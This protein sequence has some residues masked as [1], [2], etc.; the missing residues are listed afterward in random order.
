MGAVDHSGIV[1]RKARI[2]PPLPLDG[3]L[4]L[5]QQPVANRFV[6][7]QEIGGH[8]GLAGIEGLPHTMR[9]AHSF[10]SASAPTTQGLFPPSSSVTGVRRSAARAMISRPKVPPPV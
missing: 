8:A 2:A 7:Q 6:H 4:Q 10:K 9:R 1:D 3:P 5:H